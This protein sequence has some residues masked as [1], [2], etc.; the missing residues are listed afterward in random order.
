MLIP[1]AESGTDARK[2]GRYKT[3]VSYMD[4]HYAE[5]VSLQQ[6]ADIVHCNRQYL[7]RFFKEIAGV[8]PIQYMISRRIESACR[9]LDSTDKS[10]VDISMECGFDNLSYFIRKFKEKKGCTPGQYRAGGAGR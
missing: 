5:P 8:T 1:H 3:L 6:M 2:I 4:K 7:C 10:I 9:L